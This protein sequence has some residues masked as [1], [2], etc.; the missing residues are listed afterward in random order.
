MLSSTLLFLSPGDITLILVAALVLFG[1]KKLPEL[2]RG[3]GQGIKEFKDAT[4]GSKSDP[5]S[6]VNQAPPVYQA[7]PAAPPVQQAP[8][9]GGFK[10]D[11]P[12]Y[13]PVN[14]THPPAQQ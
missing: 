8:P 9:A 5:Q 13:T 4:D 12:D 10:S 11:L 3:L 2:A 7:P 1:G 14:Q 6:S